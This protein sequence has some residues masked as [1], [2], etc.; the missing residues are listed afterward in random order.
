MKRQT[1][2]AEAQKKIDEFFQKEE[3]SAEEVR[4]I[5]RLAMKYNIKLGK[6]RMM[7]CKNCLEK[8]NGKTRVS[9]KTKTVACEKCGYLN[10]FT[11][12]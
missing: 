10:R 2:R 6:Y 12:A 8:L 1:T 9:K 5:K 7:F 11:I 4:K 3:F